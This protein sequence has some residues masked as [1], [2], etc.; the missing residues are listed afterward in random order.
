MGCVLDELDPENRRR[1]CGATRG[2]GC[3]CLQ[4]GE[5]GVVAF[6]TVKPGSLRGSGTYN[7]YSYLTHN[8][9]TG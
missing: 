3:L 2:E 5:V 6:G 8:L 7:M 9:S 4:H 1:C